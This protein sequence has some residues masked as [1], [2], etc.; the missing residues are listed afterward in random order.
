MSIATGTL[1]GRYEIR[2]LIGAGGMGEVYRARDTSLG[3]DVAVKVLPPGLS[4]DKERLHRFEQEARAT[5]SLNHPNI[6]VI[7]DIGTFE[8]STY[9]VSEL[10]EGETLRDRLLGSVLPPRKAVEYAVQIA[11][12]LATAHEKGII[13]RDLKPENILSPPTVTRRF[14]TLVWRSFWIPRFL[15]RQLPRFKPNVWSH[16]QGRS[17]DQWDTCLPN[18]FA[19]VRSISV[20]T[21]FL[22]EPCCTRW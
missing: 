2:A 1:L 16:S 18:R 4:Q 11:R 10:L 7:F 9:V 8:G 5:S 20:P 13:H 17:W 3:R 19:A 6:L 12:G 22:S 21:F 15:K 14:S